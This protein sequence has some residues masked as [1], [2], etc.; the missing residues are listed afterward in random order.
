V[1]YST[2]KNVVGF[3]AESE[4]G[5]CYHNTTTAI[6]MRVALEELDHPQP[7]TPLKINNARAAGFANKSMRQ[8]ISKAWDMRYNW[9]R[10]R[11]VQDHFHIF[12]NRVPIMMR[13]TLLNI[14]HQH[15]ILKPDQI[16]FKK[17]TL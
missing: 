1:Q 11:S 2:L 8:K 4:C 5:E 12:G 3:A 13:I 14:I 15:I 17:I 16:T 10:N 6:P 7:K 9:L